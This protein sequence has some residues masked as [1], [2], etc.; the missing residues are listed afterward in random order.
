MITETQHEFERSNLNPLEQNFLTPT[1]KVN[2][3]LG[4]FNCEL[5]SKHTFRGY[6]NSLIPSSYL[7]IPSLQVFSN[8]SLSPVLS[9]TP[10]RNLNHT[11]MY[12]GT[13]RSLIVTEAPRRSKGSITETPNT[14]IEAAVGSLD[15]IPQPLISL[16]WSTC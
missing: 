15:K 5:T 16:Y 14:T 11:S 4:F 7:S 10:T 2:T 1:D 8:H 9:T 3:L 6:E 12:D 13:E